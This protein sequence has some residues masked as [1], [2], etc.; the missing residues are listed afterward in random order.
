M[1]KVFLR[2]ADSYEDSGAIER[3]VASLLD[4]CGMDAD[5]SGQKVVVKP[6]MLRRCSPAD[7][8]TTDPSVLRAVLKYL[9]EH[10]ADDITVF[11]SP[12]GVNTPEMIL[13]TYRACG[14][15]SPAEE[16]GAII[17]TDSSYTD[18]VLSDGSTIPICNV[19]L[20]ADVLIDLCKLK[21]HAMTG[22]TAA[23]KNMFGSVPGAV[24]AE[25]HLRFPERDKFCGEI[26]RI[27]EKTAPTVSLCDAIVGMEGDGPAAG[28]PR[29]FGFLAAS[30]DPFVL[31]GVLCDLI[32]MKP[33]E[34]G[35]VDASIALGLCPADPE[36]IETE[37]DRIERI[38]DLRK[39]KSTSFDF[40]GSL[41]SFLR[42]AFNALANMMT[43]RPSVAKNECVG[44]GRCA[45]SCPNKAIRI[46]G[47]K[48]EIDRELCIKCYCCHELCPKKA[49]HVKRSI[50][51]R[52]SGKS[53]T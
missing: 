53:R 49:V 31:D 44:C 20:K 14:Y 34:A 46:T 17:S 43:A 27:A 33:D 50:F 42:P 32:G 51:R 3:S 38:T 10:G 52:V 28:T 24:K 30:R 36:E 47:G 29:K 26:C 37:G 15:T 19:V 8:I 41:P 12:G 45:E 13:G 25:T 21:T 16:F 9:R 7:A 23:V 2:R 40:S 48:A 1:E 18:C 5:Y 6:N 35:T 39:A 22:M 4:N 11:D